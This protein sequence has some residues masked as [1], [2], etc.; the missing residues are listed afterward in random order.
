VRDGYNEIRPISTL[1]IRNGV[2]GRGG[3]ADGLV[4]REANF[5]DGYMWVLKKK[6]RLV[7]S[8]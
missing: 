2:G 6:K 4:I 1:V 7:C 8:K 5:P 3:G